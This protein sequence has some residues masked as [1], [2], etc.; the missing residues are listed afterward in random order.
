MN[1][2]DLVVDLVRLHEGRTARM[3]RIHK[4]IYLLDRCGGDFGLQYT[5]ESGPYCLEIDAATKDAQAQGRIEIEERVGRHRLRYT[6]LIVADGEHTANEWIG[7]L[8]REKGEHL[9]E[10]T[11]KTSDSTLGVAAAIHFL[12]D[13]L[14]DFGKERIGAVEETMRRKPLTAT[15]TRVTEALDLLRDL[16]LWS[17]GSA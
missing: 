13:E 12:L 1:A 15:P 9:I 3:S 2:E 5:Y 10:R 17:T 4:E 11:S 16:D 7:K 6:I 8:P 14:S